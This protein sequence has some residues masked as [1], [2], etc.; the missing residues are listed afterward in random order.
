MNAK[1][2]VS[3]LKAFGN[4]M[5]GSERAAL[6]KFAQVFDGMGEA[7]AAAIAGQIAKSW[8]KEGRAAKRPAELERALRQVEDILTATG[9]KTQAAVFAKVLLILAG[10]ENQNIESFVC[11]AMAARVKKVPPPKPRKPKFVDLL[12]ELART[13]TAVASDRGELCAEV[14]DGMNR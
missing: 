2:M 12:P 10:D 14:G 7:K 9:A 3:A 1:Q 8:K 5:S 6:V 4:L 13:L 11:D